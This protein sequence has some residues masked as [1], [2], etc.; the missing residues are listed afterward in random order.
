MV[1]AYGLNASGRMDLG[2]LVFSAAPVV[3]FGGAYLA[4]RNAGR[5]P[6]GVIPVNAAI[7]VVMAAASV[8]LAWSAP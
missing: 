6:D 7:T 3:A 1:L 4:Q 5:A 8:A 2:L